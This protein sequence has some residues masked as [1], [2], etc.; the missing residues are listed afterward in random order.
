M[1]IFTHVWMYSNSMRSKDMHAQDTKDT[2]IHACTFVEYLCMIGKLF[3]EEKL[4]VRAYK[5]VCFVTCTI[6]SHTYKHVRF[7]TISMFAS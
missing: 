3:V 7:S 1:D 4:H 6:H 2:Y 5:H